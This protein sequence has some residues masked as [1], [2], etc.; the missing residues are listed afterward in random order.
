ML[1]DMMMVKQKLQ[2]L[3]QVHVQRAC[4][5]TITCSLSSSMVPIYITRGMWLRKSYSM[6]QSRVLYGF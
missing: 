3:G 4:T 6:R 5:C 2:T 1:E